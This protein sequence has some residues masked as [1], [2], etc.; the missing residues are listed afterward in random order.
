VGGPRLTQLPSQF[1]TFGI[2]TTIS[3][4]FQ[5]GSCY[6]C[7]VDRKVVLDFSRGLLIFGLRV[8]KGAVQLIKSYPSK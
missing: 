8:E 5:D 7:N 4:L 1:R 2:T 6:G 3:H